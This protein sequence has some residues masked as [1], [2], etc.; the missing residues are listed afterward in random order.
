MTNEQDATQPTEPAQ[1]ATPRPKLPTHWRKILTRTNK[2]MLFS[3]DIGPVGTK[4]DVEI[5]EVTIEKVRNEDGISEMLSL[6]FVGARKRLG[7]NKG[8]CKTMTKLC[9][10]EDPNQW[11]GRITLLV[12]SE[13]IA[14]EPT[15]CIRIAP[16][17]PAPRAAK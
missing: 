14:G 11:S 4:V 15:D 5:S 17:R 12:V 7:L 3:E 1:D 8:N 2:H 10:T 16:K 6:S 9:E 13:K